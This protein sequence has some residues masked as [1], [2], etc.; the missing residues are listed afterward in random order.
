MIKNLKNNNKNYVYIIILIIICLIIFSIYYLKQNKDNF[1]NY[2][3]FEYSDKLNVNDIKEI[4]NGQKK[5]SN[6]LKVF[7]DICKKHNIRYFLVGGSLLGTI[8]YKGWIPWDGDVDLVINEHDYDKFK[9]IIQT[10]LPKTM[11]FQN[12][13]IDKHYPKHH[14]IVGK[15]RDLNSCYIEYTNNGGTQWHNGLQID[16]LLYNKNN[17]KIFSD[18]NEPLMTIDDIYPLK[19]V[20]FED[21][22]VSIMNNSEK[23]LD[24]KFGKK[25]SIILPKEE[26]LPHEGKMDSS[27]TCPFH[28]E[29][30]PNLYNNNSSSNN[31]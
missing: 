3:N 5:M 11:W 22:S 15:I 29:K 19:R 7:D 30:Y 10:E 12:Y 4:K 27:K 18:K 16:I 24:K 9:S 8:L 21:F 31:S 25:W 26:R 13:E 6:M 28:Y 1:T 20:P 23:Y 14:V 2:D 17:E